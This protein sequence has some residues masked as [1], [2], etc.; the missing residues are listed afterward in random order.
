MRYDDWDVILFPKDSHIPIQEFKTACYVSSDEYGRQLPTLTCYISSLPPTTPFRISIHSW[1]TIAK[2]SALIESRRKANQKVV[3]TV[4]VVVDGARVFRDI[5]EVASKWPQEIAHEKQILS[6]FEQSSSQRQPCLEFP[7]FH[8]QTLL[9]SS[10]DARD[11]NGRIR[12]KLSE[13]L[14]NKTTSPGEVSLGASHDI[15]CFSLQHAPKVDVLEQAGISWPIRNP[16]YFPNTHNRATLPSQTSPTFPRAP[17]TR[18]SGSSFA[19]PQNIEPRRRPHSHLPPISN[20]AKPPVGI[21][22]SGGAS[23]WDGSLAAISA[24]GDDA[25][26]DTWSTKRTASNSIGDTVMS[27]YMYTSSHPSKLGLPWSNSVP[28]TTRWDNHQSRKDKERQLIVTLRND[29]LGQLSEVISSPRRER[30]LPVGFEGQRHDHTGRPPTAHTYYPPKMGPIPLANRP[31]SAAMART[32]SYNDFNNALRNASNATSPDKPPML[33]PPPISSSKENCPFSQSLLPAPYPQANRV[34]TPNPFAQRLPS[35]SCNVSIRD[36]S[37]VFSSLSRFERSVALPPPPAMGHVKSRKEGLAFNSPRLSDQG[38]RHDQSLLT[39]MDGDPDATPK[40]IAKEDKKAAHN[41]SRVPARVE[42]IDLDA[43]DPNLGTDAA[44]GSTKRSPF[45]SM[46]KPGMSSIDSTDRLERHL[47]SA[48]GDELGSFDQQMDTT[49]MGPELAHALGG[50]MAHSNI[51]GSTMLNPSANEFEPT[52]KR[53]RRGTLGGDRDKS[54]LSKKEKG[55]LMEVDAVPVEVVP[56][57][58]GD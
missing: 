8:Q 10:W 38:V 40:P 25:S 11:P 16:L 3:Y 21:R 39:S 33:N 19:R 43:I 58:R 54:P 24:D 34:P 29:Q 18:N 50:T 13:Q 35:T 28:T 6:S 30:E 23:I 44:H 41:T 47:F 37:P 51:S 45:K 27:D 49:G 5:F 26:M 55:G 42:I 9:Q 15:V 56:R 31:S 52:I 36:S 57:L 2:P 12:I 7:A 48:L 14:I 20:F 32:S 46:H 53:K 1:A 17:K 22:G 4:Q